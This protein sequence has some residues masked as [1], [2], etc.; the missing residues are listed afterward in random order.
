[1]NRLIWNKWWKFIFLFNRKGSKSSDTYS[2]KGANNPARFKFP[3]TSDGCDSS[4]SC[5]YE[6]YLG[7]SFSLGYDVHD[8]S[9]EESNIWI[10]RHWNSK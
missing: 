8:K 9:M 1:M 6:T 10:L 5:L 3:F 2:T 4:S 7:V